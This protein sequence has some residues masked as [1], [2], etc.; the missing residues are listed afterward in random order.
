MMHGRP[1][2][3]AGAAMKPYPRTQTA[4]AVSTP[5]RPRPVCPLIVTLTV[6]PCPFN[7]TMLFLGLSESDRTLE[8]C[9]QFQIMIR[10]FQTNSERPAGG[11]HHMVNDRHFR[12]VFTGERRLRL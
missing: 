4:R 11:I 6:S 1:P 10:Q 8:A 2:A 12:S 5:A 7:T 3:N 9:G